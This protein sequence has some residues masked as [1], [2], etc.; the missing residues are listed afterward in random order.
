MLISGNAQS[1]AWV[2]RIVRRLLGAVSVG[3]GE[4]ASPHNSAIGPYDELVIIPV[5]GIREIE[6][7]DLSRVCQANYPWLMTSYHRLQR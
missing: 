3:I 4:T 6:V 2:H 1:A 5:L 7:E